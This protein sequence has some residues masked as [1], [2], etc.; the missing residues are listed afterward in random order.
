MGRNLGGTKL[1]QNVTLTAGIDQEIFLRSGF[2]LCCSSL[3]VYGH[4]IV[5]TNRNQRK[6]PHGKIRFCCR[7]KYATIFILYCILG[8]S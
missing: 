1:L 3:L 8:T 4:F 2:R 6:A 7:S 5:V